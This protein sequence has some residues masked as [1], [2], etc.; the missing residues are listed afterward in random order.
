MTAR[1]GQ[2]TTV[3]AD[4]RNPLRRRRREDLQRSCPAAAWA[5]FETVPLRE[6]PEPRRF[7]RAI[8]GTDGIWIAMATV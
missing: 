1:A 6:P 3:I 2:D 5:R 4:R 8:L 7:G